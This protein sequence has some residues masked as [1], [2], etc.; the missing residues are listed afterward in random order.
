[1][2]QFK[3]KNGQI[4]TF[5][6]ATGD[7]AAAC[8]AFLRCV[9]SETD[10]LLI[11]PEGLPGVTVEREAELLN[12]A[13][14]SFWRRFYV[15]YVEDELACIANVEINAHPRTKHN[16]TL[17]ISV[18]KKYWRQGI[19]SICLEQIIRFCRSTGTVKNLC[20]SVFANNVRAIRLYQKYDFQAEGCRKKYLCVNGVYH[21][22]LFM[23]LPL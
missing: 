17:G 7:D 6:Q 19:G 20:L 4:L 1:M 3:L 21:D 15:G 18:R 12:A 16:A 2:A 22:D 9:G 8:L 14:D 23:R 13:H 11:G 10:Y 5:R